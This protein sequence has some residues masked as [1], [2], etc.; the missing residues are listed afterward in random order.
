MKKKNH[1]HFY[2]V[3]KDFNHSG[4]EL[5]VKEETT[6]I[7]V[8]SCSLMRGRHKMEYHI[9]K[10]G[11]EQGLYKNLNQSASICVFIPKPLPGCVYKVFYALGVHEVTLSKR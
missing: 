3:S 5:S 2:D 11:A 1:F 4:K 8:M 6:L 10:E 7:L 9:I